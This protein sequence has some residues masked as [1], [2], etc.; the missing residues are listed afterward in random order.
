MCILDDIKNELKN[1]WK[2]VAEKFGD[3]RRTKVIQLIEGNDSEPIEEK[4]LSLCFKL[5]HIQ[6]QHLF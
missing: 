1:G 3:D 2:Q 6:N 5:Y 4:Q